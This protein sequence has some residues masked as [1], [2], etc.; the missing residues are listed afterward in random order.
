MDEKMLN[1]WLDAIDNKLSSIEED[2]NEEEEIEEI[3]EID[4]NLFQYDLLSYIVNV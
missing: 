1:Q 2:D 3:E 4:F